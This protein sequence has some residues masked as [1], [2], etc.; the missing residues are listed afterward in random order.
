MM[1]YRARESSMRKKCENEVFEG[2]KGSSEACEG[3]SKRE[4]RRTVVNPVFL[5]E[6][7][8]MQKS[9][10][11]DYNISSPTYLVSNGEH[12]DNGFP[13]LLPPSEMQPHP[14]VS[15]DVNESDWIRYSWSANVFP[16]SYSMDGQ[17]SFLDGL[18]QIACLSGTKNS[19]RGFLCPSYLSE[20]CLCSVC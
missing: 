2:S 8:K 6:T 4:L 10:L 1:M 5:A 3:H 9:A 19:T 20:V 7:M 13:A 15:H 18:R 14:F 17:I 16:Y 11:R 12:L